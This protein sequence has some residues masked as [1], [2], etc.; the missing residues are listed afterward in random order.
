MKQRLKPVFSLVLLAPLIAEYLLGSL[1]FAQLALFPIMALMYGA[2]ALFVRE[3]AR[4][5]GRG[6]PTMILLGLAYAVVE[7]GLATQSLFNP[8]YLGLHLLDYGF[9]SSLGI[10]GP[11]TV[12]VIVLHVAWSI[13]VPISFVECLFVAQRTT[14]WLQKTG[15]AVSGLVYFLGVALVT[16]GSHQKEKFFASRPQLLVAAAIAA[17]LAV[18]AFALPRRV[19]TTPTASQ[20]S[21]ARADSLGLLTF[22]VGSLFHLVT[23]FGQSWLTPW[24][25][26][27]IGLALPSFVIGI[28]M[29]F[30][31]AGD[32]SDSD[33]DALMLGGLLAY[34]WL[35][36]FLVV[37]LHGAGALPGQIFPFAII[38]ALIGW[39]FVWRTRRL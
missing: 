17:L 6:W 37:R 33:G 15:L 29:R 11:W 31:R 34:C 36:F 27:A 9:I 25:A 4:Q 38:A 13:A 23:Q 28:V 30:C 32:W 8:H 20:R 35:G 1:S 10:G 7:E 14:P 2:G 24:A 5:T 39:R 18:V 19:A 16:F 12:Y 21:R 22:V 3:L 26:M